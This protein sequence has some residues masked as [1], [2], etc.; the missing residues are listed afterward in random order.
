MDFKDKASKSI[1]LSLVGITAS[2]PLFNSVYAF[3]KSDLT[4]SKETNIENSLIEKEIRVNNSKIKKLNDLINTGVF[5]EFSLNKNNNL[6]LSKSIE[7]L[8]D[9]YCLSLEQVRLINNILNPGSINNIDLRMAFKWEGNAI[10]VTLTSND[11]VAFF[12]S[13]ALIGPAA[14]KAALIGLGTVVGGPIGATIASAIALLST[15]NIIS[16]GSVVIAA[17]SKNR[18]MYI[19]I[20]IGIFD[21]G[22]L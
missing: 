2:T 14:I 17:T 13:A 6:I 22:I 20:G 5:S 18:G 19:R 4:N 15:K 3:E 21:Y 16:F 7:Q 1:A 10:K 12:S 11:V 8:K 9:K